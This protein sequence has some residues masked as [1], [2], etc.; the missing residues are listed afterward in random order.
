ML[1]EGIGSQNPTLQAAIAYS[2]L[3]GWKVFPIFH[4]SKVPLTQ[5]GFYDATSDVNQIIKWYTDNPGAGIG[6]PTGKLN[7][8]VVMDIDPRNGG[9]ISVETLI[10]KYGGLPNTVKCLTPGGGEHY[11]FNYERSITKSKL[12]GYSGI[13]IQGNGRYVVLP[14]SIH[15]N[16]KKYEWAASSKPVNNPIANVPD[17][18]L[19]LLQESNQLEV[20]ENQTKDYLN[21][22]KGV[23]DGER[24]NSMMSLIGY[25]ISKKIDYRIAYELTMLWNE[26][27]NPPLKVNTV[28]RA[29]NN[30]LQKEAAKKR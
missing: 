15:P 28:T 18:L 19:K 4:K 8:L 20:K 26:K 29:F 17:F 7:D 24:N 27:N 21:I 2:E 12:A 22:L 5:H 16:G 14:P 10:G 30:I 6:L 13:D 23:T 25:L 9:D 3:L 1:N 11:Y